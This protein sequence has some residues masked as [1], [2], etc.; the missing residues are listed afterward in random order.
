MYSEKFLEIFK[1]PINAGGL[2]GA[3]GVGKYVD[4]SC[5]D[6][7]KI[8]L[9]ID[10]NKTI[11][12]AHFKALGGTATIVAGSAM[13]SCL[14][15]CTIEEALNIDEERLC[16]VTGTFPADKTYAIDFAKKALI[17]A[18]ENYKNNL[19]KELKKNPNK[20]VAKEEKPVKTEKPEVTPLVADRRNVSAAKAKFDEMFNL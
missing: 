17:N 18:I 10:E 16:E 14:L 3:N 15:D 9:K 6:S 13:C 7:I 8:Y 19:E 11:I 5:G 20:K 12:D 2:Q 4:P 1:N